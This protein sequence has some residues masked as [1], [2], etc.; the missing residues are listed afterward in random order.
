MKVATFFSLC[1]FAT[2][3]SIAQPPLG[4]AQVGD[5]YGAGTDN[6]NSVPA[7][8]LPLLIKEKDT[9]EVKVRAQ[10]LEVC[11]KKGCWMTL[12]VNDSTEAFVK[13]KDYGFF[14]PMALSGKYIVLE[15]KLF[16][17]T[18]TVA[19]LQ[20]YAEDA[21]KPKKEIDA[22][23]HDKKEIRLIAKGVLVVE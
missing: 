11:S 21:G 2:H 5:K 16:Q 8:D 15:G 22:I 4:K 19:E 20:H 23:T 7:S 9:V 14:V 17:K 18:T 10:V 12:K 1:F 3:L 6:K 13:M